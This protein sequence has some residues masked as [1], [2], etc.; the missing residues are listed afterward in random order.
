MAQKYSPS[1]VKNGLVLALDASDKS[2]YNVP[3]SV[4]VLVVAGGGGGGMDMGGGGGGGGVV[5]NSKYTVS[6]GDS[7]TVTVGAGGWGAPAGGTNRGDG[8]GPQPGSHQFTVSATNGGN[9]V[10]GNITALGGGFGASS[11]YGYLPNSGTGG[12]GGSGGGCSAY[13]HG[14]E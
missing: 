1:I 8:V 2:S 5:Y 10:F 14:G 6:K 13:T 12:S 7:I 11:Y 3:T 9:S 4:E